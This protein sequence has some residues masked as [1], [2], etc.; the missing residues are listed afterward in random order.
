MDALRWILLVIG[1]ALI[2]IIYLYSRMSS[3][4]KN[5]WQQSSDESNL[6]DPIDQDTRFHET[7]DKDLDELASKMHIGDTEDRAEFS[8]TIPPVEN[9]IHITPFDKAGVPEDMEERILVFYL[10]TTEPQG[11]QGEAIQQALEKAGLEFGDM[12][13]FHYYAD[14]SLRKQPVFSVANLVEPGTFDLNAMQTLHT[15]GLTMFMRLPGPIDSLKAFDTLV[16]VITDLKSEL[17]VELK[18]KQRSVVTRQA[19]AYLRDEIIEAQRKHRVRKGG[20]R[21]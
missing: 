1:A 6:S 11:M 19:L 12:E 7:V 15:P 3:R 5:S 16:D 4:R 9:D 20:F 17:Q 8:V 2:L 10:V 14:G 13:I 21:G 18:D